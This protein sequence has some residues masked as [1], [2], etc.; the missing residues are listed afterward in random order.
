MELYQEF[1][2]ITPGIQWNYIELYLRRKGMKKTLSEEDF[3]TLSIDELEDYVSLGY[4]IYPSLPKS[5]LVANAVS[6]FER[7]GLSKITASVFELLTEPRRQRTPILSLDT[8]IVERLSEL[9]ELFPEDPLVVNLLRLMMGYMASYLQIT[10]ESFSTCETISWESENNVKRFFHNGVYTCFSG[11][12]ALGILFDIGF[13]S[14]MEEL[15]S[16]NDVVKFDSRRQSSEEIDETAIEIIEKVNQEDNIVLFFRELE[17]RGTDE[18][19][20]FCFIKVEGRSYLISIGPFEEI[21]NKLSLPITTSVVFSD[22]P[23]EELFSVL[24]ELILS[25][26]PIRNMPIIN[27]TFPGLRLSDEYRNPGH[28]DVLMF[29]RKLAVK[30][31]IRFWDKIIGIIPEDREDL[32]FEANIIKDDLKR[33]LR[34]TSR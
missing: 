1:H 4:R 11:N 27:E 21:L 7:E 23:V 17:C 9:N 22:Y 25:N 10:D 8:G 32:F 5:N 13:Y 33:A 3:A 16:G 12:Y 34:T 15:Y 29:K 2:R 19:H 28:Y 30:D 24:N 14:D 6:L 26:D 18:T 20:D 31:F